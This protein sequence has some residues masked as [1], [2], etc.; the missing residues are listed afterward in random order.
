MGSLNDIDRERKVIA[1]SDPKDDHGELLMLPWNQIRHSSDGNSVQRQTTSTL[2]A[3]V[4]TVFSFDSPEQAHRFRTEM[5]NQFL[6]LH[7]K[8]GQGT[9]DIAIVG[10]GATGVELSA[11]LHN[12]VKELRTYGFGDSDSSKLNVNLVEGQRILPALPLVFRVQRTRVN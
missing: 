1:L 7:A 12:A 9:V 4:T 5:N 3:F 2:L 10:A 6:K 8:N 11:E